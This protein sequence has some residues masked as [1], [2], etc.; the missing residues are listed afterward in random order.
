MNAEQ[1]ESIYGRCIRPREIYSA[2][3]YK[4][5]NAALKA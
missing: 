5:Y 1:L 4:A 2:Q 3:D